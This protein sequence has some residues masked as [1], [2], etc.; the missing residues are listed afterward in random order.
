MRRLAENVLELIGR[1]PLVSVRSLEPDGR[2]SVWAK[3]EQSNPGGSVKDRICLAMIEDAERTGK[4]KPGG[5]VVEPTSGNTGIG[6]AIVCAVRGYRCVLAMPES[7]SLERRQLL[8]AYG[9]EVVLT[10]EDEQMEGAVAK[11]REIAQRTPGAFMPHQFD[12]PANPRVHG[13]TTARE[14]LEAMTPLSIDAFVV[15]VGTGGTVSGVGEVLRRELS[16]PPRIVAVEP[17]SCATIS[18]GE[19]G[20]TKIQGLGAGFIP[21]NYHP[22][23]VDEVRTVDDAGAWRTKV[24]LARREGLLVG[25]SAG[26]AVRVALDVARELGR[27]KN[28]VTLLPDTGERYFSMEEYFPGVSS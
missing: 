10:P 24:A 3:M 15:G 9:V 13:E 17:A 2:A 4:L 19:R 6:L 5:V 28:V 1:T 14:I 12:N 21:R 8:E 23:V 22:A 26:A 27:G 20:P 16:P 11:A 25:I 18:R 7:M